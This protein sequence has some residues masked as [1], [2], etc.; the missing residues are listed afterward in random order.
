MPEREALFAR[1]RDWCNR[2]WGR[3][4]RLAWPRFDAMRPGSPELAQWLGELLA[5]ARHRTY[6]YAYCPVPRGL[7]KREVFASV[8][9]VPHADIHWHAIPASAAPLAAAAS[10]LRRTK[11]PF[12]LIAG[13]SDGWGRVMRRMRWWHQAEVIPASD[14]ARLKTDN[15]TYWPYGICFREG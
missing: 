9:L 14:A 7:G 3:R 13:P 15:D 1:N 4:L 5:W 11:K 10:I 8:G 2:Q 12:D 6:V